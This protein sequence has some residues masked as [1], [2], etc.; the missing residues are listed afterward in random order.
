MKRADSWEYDEKEYKV[1]IKD[2]DK[3]AF[4]R[5]SN[6]SKKVLKVFDSENIM[7][8]KPRDIKLIFQG[9]E[10]KGKIEKDNK[11]RVRMTWN[12]LIPRMKEVFN[13]NILDF[14]DSDELKEKLPKM[15]FIKEE[16]SRFDIEMYLNSDFE[17]K[18]RLKEF[19]FDVDNM[20]YGEVNEKGEVIRR[21]INVRK[22]QKKFREKLFKLDCKCKICGM[23]IKEL[24]IAS[25]IKSWSSSTP[26]EKLS[27][28]N[29]FLLCPNHDLLFDKHLI[30]FDDEGNILISKRLSEKNKRLLGIN[31]SIKISIK[32]K[33]KIFLKEHR[34]VF[35][36]IEKDYE[37]NLELA[38]HTKEIS[39]K[40]EI[41]L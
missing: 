9:K 39:Y 19:G 16:K 24:L 20:T 1:A 41:G 13:G 17:I 25:H 38:I 31:D 30:T 37:F 21:E 26:E 23:D 14:Q 29:G 32:D 33:N 2:L 36:K 6:I 18:E 3:T 35:N 10:Y 4:I 40:V 5:G 34:K 15:K 28:Y 7:Y 12:E 11:G 22:N 8:R 27:P